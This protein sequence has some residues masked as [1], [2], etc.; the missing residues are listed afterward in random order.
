MA[1][2]TGANAAAKLPALVPG[3]AAGA[4]SIED[5]GLLRYGGTGRLLHRLRSQTTLG[6]HRRT[7]SFGHVRQL[8]VDTSRLLAGLASRAPA[9]VAGTEAVA[10]LDVDDTIHEIHGHAKQ[11]TR[12]GHSGGRGLNLDAPMLKDVVGKS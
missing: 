2:S 6:T 3:M 9:L 5:M 12:Y 8:D 1:N 11:D 7:H 4:D 10:H